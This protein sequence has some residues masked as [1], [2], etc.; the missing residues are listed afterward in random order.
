MNATEEKKTCRDCLSELPISEFYRFSPTVT[1]SRC[2]K[3]Y[4]ANLRAVRRK[5]KWG[6]QEPPPRGVSAEARKKISIKLKEWYAQNP[7]SHPWKKANR[8]HNHSVPC[9]KFKEI[10][11]ADGIAFVEEYQPMSEGRFFSLDIAFPDKK[12]AIEING[13]QHYEKDGALKPYFQERHDI[14]ERDGWKIYEI[15]YRVC[16]KPE[17]VRDVIAKALSS[18]VKVEFDYA[19]YTPRKKNLCECGT[20]KSNGAKKCRKCATSDREIVRKKMNVTDEEFAFLLKNNSYSQISR[21]FGISLK[22]IKNAAIRAG[23]QKDTSA[24]RAF[25]KCGNETFGTNKRLCPACS[26]DRKNKFFR[27]ESQV[28]EALLNSKSVRGAAKKVGLLISA[29]RTIM[30]KYGLTKNDVGLPSK[31]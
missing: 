20:E 27:T 3:C 24:K 17:K 25:C 6:D 23:L 10:L 26:E 8:K 12:V 22:G 7:L 28:K 5:K 15:F 9:E 1:T 4:C 19:S 2:K 18:D 29:F 31:V 11:R 13:T 21:M 30:R 16:Y 14:L